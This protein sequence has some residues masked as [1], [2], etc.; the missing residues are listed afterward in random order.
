MS[1]TKTGIGKIDLKNNKSG[2][3]NCLL[4]KFGKEFNFSFWYFCFYHA[5]YDF[6][7][8]SYFA[9]FT[10]YGIAILTPLAFFQFVVI[11]SLS[12]WAN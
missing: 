1:I 9:Y 5:W 2:K 3:N 8:V 10:T 11:I 6:L 12:Y 4:T 7:R